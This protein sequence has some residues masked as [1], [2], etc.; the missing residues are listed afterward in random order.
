M[1]TRDGRLEM[2]EM[3]TRIIGAPLGVIFRV[4]LPTSE[5]FGEGGGSER[6]RP[7]SQHGSCCPLP[8]RRERASAQRE[9]RYYSFG[10]IQHTSSKC[11]LYEASSDSSELVAQSLTRQISSFDPCPCDAA[12][13]VILRL[14][15]LVFHSG[16]YL[17]L[18]VD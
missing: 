1:P 12:A 16:R 13:F 10:L 5:S 4:R 2:N 14:A 17:V 8:V 9:W 18:V 11:K 15:Y 6:A 3:S 7:S